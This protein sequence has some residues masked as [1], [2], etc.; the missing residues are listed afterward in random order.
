MSILTMN[1]RQLYQRRGLW[2]A[3]LMFAF[4]VWV[5]VAVALDDPEAGGG[6]FIGLILL[7]FVIGMGAAV[8]QLEIL[9]K[10]MAFCLPRH[11]QNVRESIFSIGITVNG[12]GALLFLF[13]PGLPFLWRPVV[14][15]SAFCAG[16]IFYLAGAVLVLRY[17][18]AQTLLGLL[19]LILVGGKFLKLHVLLERIVVKYPL[20]TIGS[21]LL[22]AVLAWLYL[23]NADLA[24]RSCLRPWVGF[25]E[26]FSRDK[27]RR[28]QRRREAAPWARLK[29]HPR[30]WV[31]TF[32]LERMERHYPFGRGRFVWG[33]L[34]IALGI[35]MSQ[36]WQVALFIL[37]FA[38]VLG[39]LGPAL[40]PMLAFVPIVVLQTYFSQPSVY[41]TM[42]TAG[43]RRE[44]FAST[45]ATT[46][47]G[48][49]ALTLFIAVIS[50]ASAVLAAFLPDINYYSLTLSY[51]VVGIGAFYAPLLFLPLAATVQLI[52][53]RRPALM[54][55]ML[56]ILMSLTVLST[57]WRGGGA[58]V[59]SG[60]DTLVGTALCWLV[61][62]V[63]LTY[64]ARKRCLVR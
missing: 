24:R 21:G 33:A 13:Y 44:R 11:R 17:P 1:L 61:Y 14:L 28:S 51:R 31:Q 12:V 8:L 6:Q 63:V 16:L 42:M 40:W 55:I 60:T 41:S 34:Y 18:Q 43:G 15:A 50:F 62:L 29:D 30:P 23:D 2:L 3:Y 5:S 32:F 22:S 54:L 57:M 7:V 49:V 45:L 35:L 46:V 53:F 38:V 59:I 52:L 10:P 37:I 64:T 19:A 48:A 27:L 4:F 9:T 58:M 47:V 36:W 20:T 39:Y 56:M 25:D 26:V